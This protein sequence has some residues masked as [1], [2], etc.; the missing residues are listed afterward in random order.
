MRE[1]YP[2]ANILE[3]STALPDAGIDRNTMQHCSKPSFLINQPHTAH[4]RPLLLCCMGHSTQATG[5]DRVLLSLLLS[6]SSERRGRN[7]LQDLLSHFGISNA[8][9]CQDAGYICEKH[10][11]LVWRFL[12]LLSTPRCILFKALHRI[13]AK[14]THQ[15]QHS[16]QLPLNNTLKYN[17][18]FSFSTDLNCFPSD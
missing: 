2:A 14:Y 11:W 16:L 5:V 15:H 13:I 1:R 12:A 7:K 8:R 4:L 3:P 17:S 9:M 10:W 6:K 18:C